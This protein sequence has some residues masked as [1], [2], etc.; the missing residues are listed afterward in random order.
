MTY[1]ILGLETA[2]LDTAKGKPYVELFRHIR[3]QHVVKD[4]ASVG[5]LELDRV[6]PESE[7]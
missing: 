1:C 4:L 6:I 2:F 3:L 5:I 7:L